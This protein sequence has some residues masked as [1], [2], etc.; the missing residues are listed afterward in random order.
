M[1]STYE[2]LNA[3][4][5]ETSVPHY[6]EDNVPHDLPAGKFPDGETYVN[7]AM[8]EQWARDNDCMFECLQLGIQQGLIKV[9]ATFKSKKKGQDWTPEVGQANV[10]A[11]EW[12]SQGKPK[13]K[14]SDADVAAEFLASMTAEQRKA[15]LATL[16]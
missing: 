8:L 16:K 7:A 3:Q 6:S 4:S 14:K 15:F 11:W 2:T 12:P 5:T 1:K 13:T 10:D 9:R